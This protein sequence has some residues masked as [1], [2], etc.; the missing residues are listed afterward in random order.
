MFHLSCWR[1]TGKEI[2]TEWYEKRFDNNATIWNVPE[3][4]TTM[5]CY[6]C[7]LDH[8]VKKK[9]QNKPEQNKNLK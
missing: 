9:K 8:K 3:W 4:K 5:K 1:D 6:K 2:A 7:Y